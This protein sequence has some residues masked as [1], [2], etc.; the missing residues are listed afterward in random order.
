MRPVAAP[1]SEPLYIFKSLAARSTMLC[2]ISLS[3]E[4][5]QWPLPTSEPLY[6]L[7][8]KHNMQKAAVQ[9]VR[10]LS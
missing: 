8:K 4:C 2:V 3:V 6:S 10:L 1:T 9:I 5:G 7:H